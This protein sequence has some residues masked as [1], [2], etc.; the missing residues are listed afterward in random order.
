MPNVH[1]IEFHGNQA[2]LVKDLIR[3]TPQ[4]RKLRCIRAAQYE[5]E[6]RT[7]NGSHAAQSDPETSRRRLP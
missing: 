1:G 6:R 5:A 2:E 7:E 4:R 3:G